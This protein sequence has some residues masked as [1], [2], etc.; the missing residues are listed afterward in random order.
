LLGIRAT[1]EGLLI[2]PHIPK[3]WK[4]YRLVRN[5]RGATY[6]I[7]ILN[8]DNVSQGVKQVTLDGKSIEGNVLHSAADGRTHKVVVKLGRT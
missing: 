2:E 8:P 6:D 3:E 7:E 1:Y 4:S 5:F